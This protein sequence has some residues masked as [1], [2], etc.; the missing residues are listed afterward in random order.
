VAQARATITFRL[1]FPPDDIA[2]WANRYVEG[3]TDDEREE[4]ARIETVI[5]PRTR[6]AGY[7]SRQDFL[8]VCRWKSPRSAPRCQRNEEGYIKEVSRVALS[9]S[10]ERLRIEV[11]PLLDGVGWPTA[12]VLLHWFHTD[13]YPIL[14]V[15]ALHTL[16]AE[17]L[18][19]DFESWWAYTQ[20]CRG[21]A[22]QA[23][24]TM[25]TLDQALWRY[26]YEK[27]N[28]PSGPI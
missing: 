22:D 15:R 21:L 3:M 26:D 7:V 20:Y 27:G 14:D 8:D 24:V 25:R 12:S 5:V 1:P 18:P 28:P 11:L 17:D 19:Y 2:W 16:G 4:E 6:E 13:R 9:T 10:S 23:S